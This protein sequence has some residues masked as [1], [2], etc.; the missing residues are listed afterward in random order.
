MQKR[1]CKTACSKFPVCWRRWR[2]SQQQQINR[3]RRAPPPGHHALG[4]CC[5]PPEPP[6]PTKLFPIYQQLSKD[7]IWGVRK[8]CAEGICEIS[9]GITRAQRPQL[10]DIFERFT[11]DMS[12]WVRVAA[13][14]PGRRFNLGEGEGRNPNTT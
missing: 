4:R 2:G 5:L 14:Q 1:W 8:A 10:F 6:A 7:D 9:E 3:W 11:E 13:Y 12:R